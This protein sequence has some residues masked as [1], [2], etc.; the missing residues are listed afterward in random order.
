MNKNMKVLLVDDQ[1]R[2]IEG[3]RGLLDWQTLGLEVVGTAR[4]G[5]EALRVAEDVRP[6]I[7]ITDIIM[8]DMDGIAMLGAMRETNPYMR[9]ICVSCFDDFKFVSMAVNCGASG[10][11]LKPILA[12]ELE[13]LLRRVR[14][15]LASSM[16]DAMLSAR[17]AP[18]EGNEPLLR[19]MSAACLLYGAPQ[20]DEQEAV[21]RAARWGDRFMVGVVRP[22]PARMRLFIERR[23]PGAAVLAMNVYCVLL[24]P[25]AAGPPDGPLAGWQLEIGAALRA[26]A[27]GAGE[28]DDTD[29]TDDT[30]AMPGMGDTDEAVA[31]P[32]AGEI[33]ATASEGAM[34]GAAYAGLS[35]AVAAQELTLALAQAWEAVD[36]AFSGR[37]GRV[38]AYSELPQPGKGSSCIQAGALQ[39]EIRAM[40]LKN[41]DDALG[42]F[43]AGRMRGMGRRDTLKQVRAIAA[44]LGAQTEQAINMGDFDEAI[45][46]SAS[47][48]E[49]LDSLR[50]LFADAMQQQVELKGAATTIDKIKSYVDANLEKQLS[51][52]KISQDIFISPGYA[53]LIFKK[54]T[55]Q[56]IRQYI[57]A[58]RMLLAADLLRANPAMRV[59]DIAG[60]VG[61]D[62]AAYFVNV[63]KQLHGCTPAQ[64]RAR[65][66]ALAGGGR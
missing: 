61:F 22:C 9:V 42:E 2:E 65:S 58:R 39:R 56:T 18:L 20:Q 3:L 66:G 29:D 33:G 21:L 32:G 54:T 14:A 28:M 5:R 27:S 60:K 50:E 57:Q 64:Y 45:E 41:S 15:E 52:R 40:L 6:D 36:F 30:G 8:P 25:C 1:P 24:L 23:L 19:R 59:Y 38:C 37:S 49:I 16:H 62:D 44:L 12:N 55:G 46:R 11:I 34:A 10:F 35:D 7:V 63:F 13:G 17:F 48:Q 53:G 43:F 4:N 26:Y 47:K 51:I 31:L